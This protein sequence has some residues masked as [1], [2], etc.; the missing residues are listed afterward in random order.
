MG[1]LIALRL[2]RAGVKTLV[3][4]RH[5]DLLP[6][7]RA[8]VYQPVVLERLRD[9]GILYRVEEFAHLNQQGIYWRDINGNELGH[10]PIPSHE[11][12]LLLGQWRM[13]IL[14]LDE[15]AKYPS[16]EV[17]F[18]T[19]YA[20]CIQE[21]DHVKVMAHESSAETDDDIMYTA[22]WLVGT[23]G[24]NSSVR[25]SLCVPFEGFSFTDF[26]M[27]GADVLYDF[28]NEQYNGS[29]LNFIVD[30]DDCAVVIYTGQQ[31]DLKPPGEAP[32][33]WRVA[34]TESSRFPAEPAEIFKRA[35]GRC[36]KYAK[37]KM[38]LEITRAEPYRLHQ[39]C[40][41]QAIKGRVVL[42]GDALHSNNP[43]GGLGLTTGICDAHAIGNA[44]ARVCTGEA[45][46]SLVS[47]AANDRRDTWLNV[48]DKLSQTN[49]KRLY[50]EHPDD[51]KEREGFFKA[52]NSDPDMPKK[53]RAS[54][55]EIAGKNFA[56]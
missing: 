19:A 44:L 18:S 12:I 14:I 29:L 26:R 33:L 47:E 5:D 55:E 53:V 10:L 8:M 25:R 46:P 20:G 30:P 9:L 24:A 31:K 56:E 41:A 37:G 3:V 1:L 16:V 49:L 17:R 38:D 4:E 21:D 22:D 43:I 36:A 23:D 15:L 6:T 11:H 54:V 52:L 48:T 2:G 51:A 35:Q 34:Y 39:R 7:T 40:A 32:P 27:I 45:P 13:N 42:A 50:S 28:G